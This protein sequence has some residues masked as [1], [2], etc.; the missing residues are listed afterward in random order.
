M[1]T[2]AAGTTT[3][4]V[5][6]DLWRHRGHLNASWRTD[7]LQVQPAHSAMPIFGP[8]FQDAKDVALYLHTKSPESTAAQPNVGF[9]LKHN[10]SDF[11]ILTE[12]VSSPY[13]SFDRAQLFPKD[14]HGNPLIPANFVCM[15]FTI[16]FSHYQRHVWLR[17]K[18]SFSR[19]SSLQRT[20]RS[21]W[22]V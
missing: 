15:A 21:V 1:L 7:I 20:S 16:R 22:T 12:P 8:I 2:L 18:W 13:A 9:I 5:T 11:F 17:A 19:I 14:Q 4:V 10:V 3:V 6:G